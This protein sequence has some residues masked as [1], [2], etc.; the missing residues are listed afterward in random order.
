MIDPRAAPP[1]P[2]ARG[3]A[4]FMVPRLGGWAVSAALSGLML[5]AVLPL[6][7][8][9]STR[10]VVV[11]VLLSLAAGLSL[12]RP[13]LASAGIALVLTA[14][15]GH[16]PAPAS[17]GLIAS[18]VAIV[19]CAAHGRLLCSIL[20]SVWLVS[21][22]VISAA[23]RGS[24]PEY[25]V[26]ETM[27]RVVVLTAAVLAGTWGRTMLDRAL[28]ERE[29]R[30]ADL[31]EQRRAIARELHDTG[32]RAMTQ[33]VMLAENASRR[34]GVAAPDAADFA[35]IATTSRDAAEELRGLLDSL[36]EEDERPLPARR[37]AE[38]SVT[39]L[40]EEF[41]TQLAEEG[42]AARLAIDSE[43]LELVDRTGVLRR[44][45]GEIRANLVRHA[46]RS[47]PVTVM[48]EQRPG[49]PRPEVDLAV[50]N[51][52]EASDRRGPR[53]GAGLDGMRE[54]LTAIGGTLAVRQEGR[55]FLT[56]LTVPASDEMTPSR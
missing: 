53:G 3:R 56:R 9:A 27:L 50:W 49:P 28:A 47:T 8:W 33:V 34:E 17:T 7:S 4:W 31:A 32:V 13:L 26:S 48:V 36:R 11:G 39:A 30:I 23:L 16:T 54:R 19:S 6:A 37:D 24:S 42:F 38:P 12:H 1:P 35:R 51:G 55:S 41:R 14:G 29:R 10:A 40:L 21:P 20:L 5:V 52:V 43:Q 15:I 22:P 45:L 2:A 44:C 18:F 46:S 25:I